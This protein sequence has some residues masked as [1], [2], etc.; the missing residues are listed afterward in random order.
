MF[1]LLD[2][3]H[4]QTETVDRLDHN[5]TAPSLLHYALYHPQNIPFAKEVEEEVLFVLFGP[6]E[7]VSHDID[8]IL[9]FLDLALTGLEVEPLDEV[10]VVAMSLQIPPQMLET[11]VLDLDSHFLSQIMCTIPC[12][13]YTPRGNPRHRQSNNKSTATLSSHIRRVVSVRVGHNDRRIVR[14]SY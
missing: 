9:E 4:D 13:A 6:D 5:V 8:G 12:L 10:D 14:Y 7:Q 3:V 1:A 2:V 11:V